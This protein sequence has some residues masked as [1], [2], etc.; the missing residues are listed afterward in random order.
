[1][2]CHRTWCRIMGVTWGQLDGRGAP[3]PF[4]WWHLVGRSPV[5]P[6][7]QQK[8]V[9][10]NFHVAVMQV[11]FMSPFLLCTIGRNSKR[12]QPETAELRQP[13]PLFFKWSLLLILR[14]LNSGNTMNPEQFRIWIFGV[15]N[16]PPTLFPSCLPYLALWCP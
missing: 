1:M 8:P 5:I 10:L 11:D 3:R 13:P 9:V 2:I 7:L 12:L 14:R 16:L 15:C 6:V 4:L